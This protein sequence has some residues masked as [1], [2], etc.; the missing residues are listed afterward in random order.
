[1]KKYEF[2]QTKIMVDNEFTLYFDHN[3]WN[4]NMLRNYLQNLKKALKF[5]DFDESSTVVMH[6]KF[7]ELLAT[8][9]QQSLSLSCKIP[10][11]KKLSSSISKFFNEISQ[12]TNSIISDSIPTRF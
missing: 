3:E 6:F 4:K 8:I 10:N 12:L 7:C 11:H 9:H 2:V 5:K 1:M